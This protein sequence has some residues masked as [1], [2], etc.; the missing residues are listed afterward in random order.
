MNVSQEYWFRYML[1]MSRY[2]CARTAYERN[3]SLSYANGILR[4]WFAVAE[5][6]LDAAL[7]A[8]KQTG[9]SPDGA[10]NDEGLR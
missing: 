9:T 7:A 8:N 2:K 10:A 6:E 5:A 4:L 3:R 1:E